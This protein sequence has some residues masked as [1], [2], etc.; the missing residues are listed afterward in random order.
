M[1]KE[2]F[3]DINALPSSGQWSYCLCCDLM[4][5]L[6]LAKLIL[7]RLRVFAEMLRQLVTQEAALLHVS[8]YPTMTSLISLLG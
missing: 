4:R 7:V 5:A 3:A 8:H 2:K 6:G 1:V